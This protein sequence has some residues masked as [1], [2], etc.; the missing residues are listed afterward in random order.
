MEWDNMAV[1]PVST[2]EH[3]STQQS[4]FEARNKARHAEKKVV[5]REVPVDDVLV[6]GIW[7]LTVPQKGGGAR[8]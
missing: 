6:R 8:T 3:W 7:G 5:V 1:L 4:G 2:F